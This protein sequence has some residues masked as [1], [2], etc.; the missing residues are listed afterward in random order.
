MTPAVAA[1]QPL[2]LTGGQPRQGQ[3]LPMDDCNGP[4]SVSSCGSKELLSK[5]PPKTKSDVVGERLV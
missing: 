5:T 3:S 1:A 4:V 2:Q